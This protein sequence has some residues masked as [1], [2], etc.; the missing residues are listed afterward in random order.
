MK[1]YSPDLRE[2][3]LRAVDQGKSRLPACS[4]A[5]FFSP[6][7]VFNARGEVFFHSL[8]TSRIGAVAATNTP[9]LK[10]DKKRDDDD[11]EASWQDAPKPRAW[12][13]D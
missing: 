3:V 1:A 2:K 7:A 12:R 11:D 4:A 10:G 5:R 6:G 9:F 13:A 8:S